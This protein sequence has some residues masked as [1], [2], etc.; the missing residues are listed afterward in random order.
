[1]TAKRLNEILGE[2]LEEIRGIYVDGPEA[3]LMVTKADALTKLARQQI[4]NSQI[5]LRAS[6]LTGNIT[7]TKAVASDVLG[8][9]V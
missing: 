3:Q 5:R 2:A 4:N 1:M 9:P 6:Q 7:L 8:D